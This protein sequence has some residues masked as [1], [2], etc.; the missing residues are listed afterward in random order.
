MA[1]LV[2]APYTGMS[3]RD[4]HLRRNPPSGEP[5]TDYYMPTGTPL[6]APTR[7]RV[8]DNGGS[9]YPA[10]GRYVT[11]DDGVR[12]I[13]FLHLLEWRCTEGDELD[14]GEVFGISGASGYG[15]EFFG[16]PYRN[17]AFWQNTGGDH[18]HVTAFKGRAYTFGST[19]TVDFHAMTGGIVAGIGAS[20]FTPID[21]SLLRRQK[22][23][24]MYFQAPDTT[25]YG[26]TRDATGK[27]F[28]WKAGDAEAAIA[29]HGGLVIA[30]VD[31]ATVTMI[32]QEAGYDFAAKSS[33]VTARLQNLVWQDSVVERPGKDGT[34][35]RVPVIQELADAKSAA[36]HIAERLDSGKA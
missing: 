29:K 35:V 24:V 14:P 4:A 2:P 19:G 27:P 21:H 17:N 7:C 6:R 13:R 20:V 33:P 23:D 32:G 10:T 1:Y 25:V 36:L 22:E 30:G 26:F 18:V 12:W 11:V 5:G 34:I 15:S 8:V 28:M 16:E 3:S 31:A 9:I